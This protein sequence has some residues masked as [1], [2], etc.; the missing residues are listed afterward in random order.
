MAKPKIPKKLQK[1]IARQRID[2][3]LQEA[4]DQAPQKQSLAN[5]YVFLARKIAM[6]LRLRLEP[7]QKRQYCK[8]CHTFLT[9]AKNA[10]IRTARGKVVILCL[11]CKHHMRIPYLKEQKEKGKKKK[12]S[13]IKKNGQNS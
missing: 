3:L 12:N 11:D 7:E 9:P 2:I 13:I 5:R 1:K 10:R 6:K 4:R 8:N